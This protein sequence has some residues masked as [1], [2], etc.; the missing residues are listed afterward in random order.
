MV[1]I[2][3]VL[4]AFVVEGGFIVDVVRWVDVE[5]VVEDVR[6]WVGGVDVGY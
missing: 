2:H 3:G 1:I 5:S 6:G 4:V